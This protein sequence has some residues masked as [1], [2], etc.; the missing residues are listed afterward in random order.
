MRKILFFLSAS[1]ALA[2]CSSDWDSGKVANDSSSKNPPQATA[3]K[4]A[5]VA[6]SDQRA[7]N[8][9]LP[10]RG[11]LIAYDR[12]RQPIRRGAFT[13][14]SVELSEDHALNAAHRG[15]KIE[16]QTPAGEN[17]SFAY[18][19]HVDH[20]DGNWTWVGRTAE[21]LDAVLTFGPEAVIGRVSQANTESLQLSYSNGRSWLVEA[22][23]AKLRHPGSSRPLGHDIAIIPKAA[24]ESVRAKQSA[25]SAKGAIAANNVS[26]A[27][28][29]ADTVDVVL[30]YTPGLVAQNS[31]SV[32]ATVTMLNNR[33]EIANQAFAVSLVT[34]RV[35]LV[36]TLQVNYTDTN[37]NSTALDQLSGQTCTPTSCSSVPI[38]TELA[39]LR[40]ARDTFGGDIV[41][42]VRPLREPQQ[43]GCGVAWLLGPN[44]T[45][46]DNT[47]A[48][49]A[50]SIVSNGS[51]VNESD[52]F[53]YSC[54]NETLAHEMAHNM[55]QQ[56]NPEDS[57]GDSG[58]HTYSY[59]YR[60]AASNGFYTIMAYPISN[61]QQFL[62]PYY[63]NP[64]VNHPGTGRPTGTA[65]ADNARSLNQSMLLVAQ[66]RNTVVPFGVVKDD[67]NGDGRSDILWRQFT[68]NQTA[69]WQMNGSAVTGYTFGTGQA[70]YTIVGTGDFGGDGRIDILW[71][72][73]GS[74]VLWTS[75]GTGFTSAN[76]ASY[77]DGWTLA[78][79]ADANG[80]GR[81]DIIWIQPQRGE[82][83]FWYMN[84]A[85]ASSYG[86]Q[87]ALAGYTVIG[88]GDFNADGRFDLLWDNGGTLNLWTSTGTGFTSANV[89]SYG[90][91]WKP[92]AV[93]DVN[94]D[95]RMDIIWRQLAQN[96]IA[97][98]FMNGASVTGYG[99]RAGLAGYNII[100]TGDFNGDGRFDLL[101]DNTGT[102][103]VWL[104]T[105]T[106][107]NSQLVASYGDG[108]APWRNALKRQ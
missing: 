95:N 12:A 93:A 46:I 53:T 24:I 66:F 56:H 43:A 97:Y 91:G 30:G 81:A 16:L 6:A 69:V 105:G 75:T 21:G 82:M 47:D 39:P 100:G 34:P 80:D 10:D 13:Y 63:G 108:W 90:D 2:G 106:D 55:G 31:N 107:F 28:G 76:V 35:R 7:V 65:T 88:A 50:Y 49:F 102:M 19:R 37:S 42:L 14:H 9:R 85:T 98:W 62:I 78:A 25:P 61:S 33:V 3:S 77:G 4:G 52:G 29:P 1:V 89:A 48:P 92:E 73:G 54:P 5:P 11:K 99:F 58:T 15:G 84:G 38:P 17:L 8:A 45:T 83:A 96:Q 71:D 68:T 27:T 32:S 74:L 18:D 59:G 79:V 36:H 103:Y 57:N 51:D 101:W 72:N 104:S 86:F 23:P 40:T 70:G 67:M 94:G 60:E 20:G 64:S 41:S 26:A 22:D 44:N 87:P